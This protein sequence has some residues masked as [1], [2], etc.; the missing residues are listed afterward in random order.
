MLKKNWWCKGLC[1]RKDPFTFL[2]I[3][4]FGASAPVISINASSSGS[5]GIEA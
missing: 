4:P 3:Y 1:V 5:V 2:F